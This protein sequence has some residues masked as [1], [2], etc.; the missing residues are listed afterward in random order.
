MNVELATGEQALVR[1]RRIERPTSNEKQTS[2][3][4]DFEPFLA[5]FRRI[6]TPRRRVSGIKK[7]GAGSEQVN[8]TPP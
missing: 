3:T 4:S 6:D 5:F 2:E 7:A 8:Y 1:P